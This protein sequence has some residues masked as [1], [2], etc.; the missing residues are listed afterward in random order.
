VGPLIWATLAYVGAIG[1]YFWW[2]RTLG[3]FVIHPSADSSD[4][5]LL[6]SHRW[7]NLLKFD[8]VTWLL[9]SLCAFSY[10]T[11][12]MLPMLAALPWRRA[13]RRPLLVVGLG[14]LGTMT[15]VACASLGQ[16]DSVLDAVLH[17]T[18]PYLQNLVYNAGIGPLAP[19][20]WPGKLTKFGHWDVRVWIAIEFLLVLGHVL[21]AALPSFAEMDA[22]RR[23]LASFGVAFSVLT[24]MVTIQASQTN[25]FDRYLFVVLLGGILSMACFMGRA[26]LVW[27]RGTMVLGIVGLFTIGGLH[28]YFAFNRARW[29]LVAVAQSHGVSRADITGGY[30][31]NGWFR[32]QFPNEKPRLPVIRKC[33]DVYCLNDAFVIGTVVPEGYIAAETRRVQY[34]LTNGPGLLLSHRSDIPGGWFTTGWDLPAQPTDRE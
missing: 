27:W 23:E 9:M 19:G 5:R 29:Q 18:F 4:N 28:D 34:W 25:V 22:R 10:A 32:W 14:Y 13:F 31:V 17:K 15:A 12:F 8:P 33:M 21:W 30:E 11:F 3:N 7:T 16:P 26:R 24:L 6:S 2:V 20:M 1:G